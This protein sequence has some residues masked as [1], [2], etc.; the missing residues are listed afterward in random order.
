MARGASAAVQTE[1]GKDLFVFLTA[2]GNTYMAIHETK[3][4]ES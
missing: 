2:G 3:F 1:S 4:G